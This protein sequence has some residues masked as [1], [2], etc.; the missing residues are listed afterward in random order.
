M[1]II[2]IHE[3]Y[4]SKYEQMETYTIHFNKTQ[5]HK[6]INCELIHKFI[7]TLR[8]IPIEM[9]STARKLN[10]EYKVHLEKVIKQNIQKNSVKRR[11]KRA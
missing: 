2:N 5:N 3:R 7:S 4:Y 10:Y 6:H 11:A 1:K 8:K 9:F